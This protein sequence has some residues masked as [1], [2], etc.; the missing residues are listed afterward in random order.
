[1]R[2]V[3]LAFAAGLL[4]VN[5]GCRTKPRNGAEVAQARMLEIKGSDPEPLRVFKELMNLPCPTDAEAHLHGTTFLPRGGPVHQKAQGMIERLKR[6]ADEKVFD[7]GMDYVCEGFDRRYW[8]RWENMVP[9][10]CGREY[11]I[12]QEFPAGLFE[13]RLP[14]RVKNASDPY[15]KYALMFSFA[16]FLSRN[17]MLELYGEWL[18]DTRECRPHVTWFDVQSQMGPYYNNRLCDFGYR[19]MRGHFDKQDWWTAPLEWEDWLPEKDYVERLEAFK[20][21]WAE[22]REK[23][24]RG[25]KVDLPDRIKVERDESGKPKG[26]G[27]KAEYFHKWKTSKE[28]MARIRKGEVVPLPP[29]P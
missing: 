25:E 29:R 22:N 6:I 19:H 21:W 24:L 12:L 9:P 8:S 10:K 13:K 3:S 4:V 11:E 26:F 2:N 17:T 1:M 5:P 28:N 23:I 15:L 16:R 7:L 27:R 18:E 14:K 20:R